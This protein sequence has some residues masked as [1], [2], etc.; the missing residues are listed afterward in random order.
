MPSHHVATLEISAARNSASSMAMAG[1]PLGGVSTFGGGSS[2]RVRATAALP[3]TTPSKFDVP[4]ITNRRYRF[5]AVPA[6]DR[7]HGASGILWNPFENSNGNTWGKQKRRTA[8]AIG[9]DRATAASI[10]KRQR[11]VGR[12]FI[13]VYSGP[14]ATAYFI[15]A[16]KPPERS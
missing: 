6:D 15:P 13:A 12:P 4:D 10:R 11:S 9:E 3:N 5:Q 7:R 2:T 1:L 8:K 16:R 14:P